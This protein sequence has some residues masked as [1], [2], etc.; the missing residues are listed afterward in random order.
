MDVKLIRRIID[1]LMLAIKGLGRQPLLQGV[2]S[3]NCFSASLNGTGSKAFFPGEKG[4]HTPFYLAKRGCHGIREMLVPVSHTL[5]VLISLNTGSSPGIKDVL[6]SGHSFLQWRLVCPGKHVKF[7][8]YAG[9]AM[10]SPGDVYVV[11]AGQTVTL[12]CEFYMEYF[13]LFDNPVIWKKS[14]HNED[15][16]INIMGNIVPP[17]LHTD[18]FEV[19]FI[20][21]PPKFNLKLTMKNLAAEDSGNYTC[22]V[23]GEKSRVISTVTFYF[24]VRA[25]VQA[26]TVT[27]DNATAMI[28]RS[29]KTLTFV[30]HQP[31]T[32]RCVSLGGYPPPD[33]QLFLSDNTNITRQFSL[34]YASSLSGE[35]GLKHMTFRT[36]RWTHDFTAS[37]KYD[38][39]QVKCLVTVPGLEPNVSVINLQIQYVPI[40]SCH[41]A[42]ARLGDRNI[43]IRCEIKARP[44]V[45]AFHWVLDHNGTTVAEGQIKGE[46]WTLVTDRGAFLLETRLYLREATRETFRKYTLVAENSL[47]KA[48][49]EIEL[50][51]EKDLPEAN[52]N[53][54]P[55]MGGDPDLLPSRDQQS[56][57]GYIFTNISAAFKSNHLLLM[58]LFLLQYLNQRCR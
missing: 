1:Q 37:G 46:Y 35:K 17:F 9:V 11:N 56:N 16:Q 13:N 6:L 45:T 57:P 34:S 4:C 24:F 7:Y 8:V 32:L 30:E 48:S 19:H 47:A 28:P 51:Q 53:V 55:S 40:I 27:S 22:E 36:E 52:A 26:I 41:P 39:Q 33:M 49:Q 31:G 2:L 38:G 10:L 54:D 14:Q 3:G 29:T 21:S 44:R 15:S 43:F 12:H 18:R 42:S 23:R 20:Q 58:L 25:P 50:V 5:L